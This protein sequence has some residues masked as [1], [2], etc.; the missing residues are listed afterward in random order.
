MLTCTEITLRA[1]A[2]AYERR[3]AISIVACRPSRAGRPNLNI[4]V[5]VM[6]I[7]KSGLYAVFSLLF[8]GFLRS[9][10]ERSY[11]ARGG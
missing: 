9:E 7:E 5:G 10:C 2:V 3:A 6:I 4:A 11:L 1:D 8:Q